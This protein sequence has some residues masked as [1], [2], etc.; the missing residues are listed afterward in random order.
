MRNTER[1]PEPNGEGR[2]ATHQRS[3]KEPWQPPK[4]TFIEPKLTKEGE[5]QGITGQ[6][7]FG[8]FIA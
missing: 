7:F 8:T 5:L 6:G 2:P 1:L 3:S 4:L